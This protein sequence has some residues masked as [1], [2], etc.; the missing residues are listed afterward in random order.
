MSNME[1]FFKTHRQA[2]DALE[3]APDAWE[4]L[5]QARKQ[6][7]PRQA[8]LFQLGWWKIAAAFA[9]ISLLGVGLFLNKPQTSDEL[10]FAET[11]LEIQL[12]TIEGTP[13]SLSSL[14]GKVVLVK[15]WASWSDACRNANCEVYL[16]IYEKYR[17]QGFE[18]FAVSLDTQAESWRAHVEEENLCWI[19]VCDFQGFQSP[20][21]ECYDVKK[22]P[23]TYLLDR[24]LKIVA[25]DPSE[26]ELENK[27]QE[28]LAYN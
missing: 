22:V 4:K 18:I 13:T 10:S 19:Q 20:I 16:P 9:I 3:P 17:D 25:K 26:K 8:R 2:F 14:E 7:L 5:Q 12:E 24:D 23:T 11:P 1:Q 15:F 21:C 6:Q 27:L 28:L